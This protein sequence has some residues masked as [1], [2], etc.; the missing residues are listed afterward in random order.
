MSSFDNNPFA[1]QDANN[2]FSDPS[3]TQV[4]SQSNTNAQRGLEDYNPFANQQSKTSAVTMS[5]QK[6]KV[7]E[8]G[9]VSRKTARCSAQQVAAILDSDDEETLG[10][11]EDYPSDELKTDSDDNVDNDNDSESDSDNEN[12]VDRLPDA[13][14]SN[15]PSNP[16][17]QPYTS[18]QPAVMHPTQNT[19]P[20]PYTPTPAQSV[21]TSELQRRQEELEKK[22]EELQKKEEALR[23]Q[24]YNSR[25]NNWPP[26]P[27]KCCVGPCFYQDI[28]V[29][30][31]LEFQKVVRAGYYLWMYHA[32][33][34]VCNLLGSL[35]FLIES[36]SGVTFGMSLLFVALFMP[37]SF[38][39][40]FRPLY[41]AFRSDSSFNFFIFFFVFFFQCCLSIL[42]AIGIP[43]LGSCGFF[44]GLREV[45]QATASG[46]A[47]GGILLII[48]FLW[49]MDA[50]ASILLL[51][52]FNRIDDHPVVGGMMIFIG[53]MFTLDAILC[54]SIILKVHRIYRSTDA[55]FAK[56]QA[57]FTTGVM[58]NEH[59]QNAAVSVA[60]TAA[61]ETVNQSFGSGGQNQNQN[62][63]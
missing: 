34:L 4:T 5:S 12:P 53:G 21:T 58:K 36:G 6:R 28:T 32:L 9:D 16:V 47:V 39:C 14:P 55:S 31:P 40:W 17:N 3:V 20:P 56:A 57:E 50:L 13:R 8:N 61:R 33:V 44:N 26:L 51:Y 29:D 38:V 37:L 52:K 41:K 62:R 49:G 15:P 10:F 63:Y 46:Y 25:Q 22:A 59:V 54:A 7:P 35:A 60:S 30:I 24:P 11:D 43:G 48:G 1:D 27:Q 18:S 2:P 42:F 23:G 45:T 19:P